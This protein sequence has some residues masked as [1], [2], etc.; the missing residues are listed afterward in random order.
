MIPRPPRSTRTDKLF[1]Y[2]TLF[3]SHGQR[4]GLDQADPAD[5]RQFA[6]LR[7]LLRRCEGAQELWRGLSR[8][9][10]RDQPRLGCR[11]ISARPRTRED[12]KST[13]LT[14]VTNAHLV[15]RLLLEKKNNQNTTQRIINY[16]P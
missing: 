3:R 8:P 14:P 16:T 6:L 15:C 9:G 1:P 2:T 7:N 12:R 4:R 5:Q 10:G 13:R 11:Q